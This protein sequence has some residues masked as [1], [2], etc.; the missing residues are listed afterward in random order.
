MAVTRRQAQGG[1]PLALLAVVSGGLVAAGAIAGAV[2]AGGVAPAAW[3]SA[4]AVVGF[5]HAHPSAVR[6]TA[7]LWFGSAVP[8]AIYAATVHARLRNLGV[9]A[10]GATIAL[11][12]GLLGATMWML[13]AC[14]SWVLARPEVAT[15]PSLIRALTDAAYVTGGP[16]ALAGLGLLVAGMAVP[17]LLARLLPRPVAAIG[18]LLAASAEVASV[19]LLASGSWPLRWVVHGLILGWLVVAGVRLPSTRA[20]A[21]GPRAAPSVPTPAMAS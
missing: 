15:S 20:S 3:S 2:V 11:A 18:L 12:G 13:A 6:V 19:V 14:L 9:R 7:A 10:P 8:L 21:S 4:A 5:L 17:S 16:A 1:P